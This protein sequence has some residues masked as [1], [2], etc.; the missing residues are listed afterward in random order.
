MTALRNWLKCRRPQLL[1]V[2]LLLA[3]GGLTSSEGQSGTAIYYRGQTIAP[4][5]EGW[6]EQP[7]GT[8]DL[9][10]GY[11]NRN[12]EEYFHIPVG[13]NNRVEPGDLDRGQPTY[14][15]P[16]RNHYIFRVRVPKDFGKKEVAWFVTS[17]GKTESAYGSLRPEYVLDDVMMSGNFGGDRRSDTERNK[18][19][20]VTI[21]GRTER[22]VR[23]NEPLA[24]TALASDDGVPKVAPAPNTAFSIASAKGLRVTWSVYR[25]AG[26]AVTFA[27]EQFLP[28]PD[29][30]KYAN[31]PWRAGWMPPPLPADGKFPVTVTFSEPGTYV[32]RVIASDGGLTAYQPVTV[33]VLG[34]SP[35]GDARSIAPSR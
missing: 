29:R 11:L 17:H 12:V 19:P 20:V 21:E 5:F 14:F 26:E 30:R 23:V 8:F 9:V 34:A 6:E 27:P 33:T 2:T 22:T 28:Y 7:D 16:G 4:A 24:L 32:L 10:F 13:P 1:G 18:K 31:S 15:L 3:V 25:G 35:V